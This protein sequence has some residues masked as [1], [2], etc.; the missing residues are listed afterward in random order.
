MAVIPVTPSSHSIFSTNIITELTEVI[1]NPLL[2]IEQ[3]YLCVLDT[4]HRF[5]D[6]SQNKCIMLAANISYEELKI[7]KG[8]PICFMHAAEVT[9]IHHNAVLTESINRS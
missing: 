5:Y 4:L 2:Y 3:S 8:M 9:N 1:E 7:N 6:R